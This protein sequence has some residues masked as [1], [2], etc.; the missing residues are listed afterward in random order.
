MI[1]R[2]MNYRSLYTVAFFAIASSCVSQT[3]APKMNKEAQSDTLEMPYSTRSV[4]NFC[5]VIGWQEEEKPSAPNGFEVTKYAD[6]FQNPRWLYVLP[7]GDLLVAES[8]ANHTAL[9]K[10]TETI[11]GANQSTDLSKSA[12]RITLLRDADQDGKPE[13]RE[14][15]LENLN[16]PFGMLLLG[17]WLYVANTDAVMRFP[18]QKGQTKIRAQGKKV[19]DLPAGKHNFHW[20]RNII[21]NKTGTKLYIAVGADSNIGENGMEEEQWRADIIE[22]N[23]DGTSKRIYAS[24]LRNPVG[25]GWAPGS[26]LLWVTV[27]ER[28]G[29]GDDLVP[30][31]LDGVKEGAFYGW[32]YSYFGQHL[33]PRIKPEDQKPDLVKK[34]VAPDVD[35]G[36]HTASM[37]LVFYTSNSFPK[38]F[39]NGAFIAQHGSWNRSVLSG[40]RVVFVPF[41]NGKP[42][43]I[44]E[45][46]LTGFIADLSTSKVHGRPVGLAISKDGALLVA[47]DVSNTIW[48]VQV[49]EQP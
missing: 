11:V 25:M 48:K 18:Y 46:F 22:M 39:H 20:T 1:V 42:S 41:K 12:D 49:L 38:K 37:G 9:E 15:F 24:G 23:P 29:L 19:T 2:R 5:D 32:P 7:N 14:A 17:N 31:Y 27:N 28:D 30:D 44:P 4:T 40:Y 3:P 36:S 47:D 45:E 16:Q 6:D 21:A 33:D 43:G 10:V 26:P 34:A 35:L 8:N 13:I